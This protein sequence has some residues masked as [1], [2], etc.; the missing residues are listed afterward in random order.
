MRPEAAS[1]GEWAQ[2]RVPQRADEW[3][4]PY[5]ILNNTCSGLAAARRLPD[6]TFAAVCQWILERTSYRLALLGGPDDRE[7]INQFIAAAPAL[8]GQRG[9]ILNF[10]GAT[11]GFG[12]YYRFL[13]EAGSFLVTIDSGPL[14]IAR[15]LGLPTIS[16]WGPTDPAHYLSVPPEE[17][18]RHLIHY[19]RLP[20]SPCVHRH[21]NLPC[22]GNNLCMKNISVA[23]ITDKIRQMLD[24]LSLSGRYE[25]TQS[26][27]SGSPVLI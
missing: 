8:A 19:L 27:E 6:E 16:I 9:R 25:L 22:G 7:A 15:R 23:A 21:V 13:R 24:H 18:D 20:C 2:G 14:H 4:R 10:A 12:E 26:I 17:K 1:G 5:I 3:D 11:E